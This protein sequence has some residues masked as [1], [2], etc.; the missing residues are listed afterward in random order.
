M[1]CYGLGVSRVMGV[2]A[3]KFMDEKGLVWPEA[4]APYSHYMIVHGDHMEVAKTLAEKL[5]KSGA[6]V[7]I[8]DRNAGFGQKAGDADLLGIPNRIILSDKTLAAGGY[9]LKKRS[10]T[11]GKMIAL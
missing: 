4:I 3:E 9:E 5:E 1:G 8:D 2:I 7:L 6:E 11:E 10:E